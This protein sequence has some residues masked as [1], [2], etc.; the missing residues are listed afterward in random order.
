MGRFS[1]VSYEMVEQ[2]G[3][4]GLLLNAEEKPYAPPILR[5]GVF[6]E[7]SG[8]S[9]VS[10]GVG[11]RIRISG[12]GGYRSEWRSDFLLAL[13]ILLLRNTIGRLARRAAGLSHRTSK[14]AAARSTS[15]KK[16]E[17]CP[18]SGRAGRRGLGY[19]VSLQQ[20]QRTT[21]RVRP[22][23]QVDIAQY[24]S[25]G[26]SLWKRTVRLH[27][28]HLIRY[29]ARQRGDSPVGQVPRVDNPTLRRS[30]GECGQLHQ[31]AAQWGIF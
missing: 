29:N 8:L 22:R 4:S 5:P 21:Y 30:S 14:P 20:Q 6:I 31:R 27:L 2:N 18:V 25:T 16:R 3:K 17:D 24:W 19:W 1:T 26:S 13:L 10:F 12:F 11:G 9:N 28:I 23:L 15:I 7:G